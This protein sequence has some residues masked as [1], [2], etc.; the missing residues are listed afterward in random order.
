MAI[1]W[2]L[3]AEHWAFPEVPRNALLCPFGKTW[4][5]PPQARYKPFEIDSVRSAVARNRI[6][7]LA[8]WRSRYVLQWFTSFKFW[9]LELVWPV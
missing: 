3:L 5:H 2:D 7:R 6:Q 1:K 8:T 9:Q 4:G